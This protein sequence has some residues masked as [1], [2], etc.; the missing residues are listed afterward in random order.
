MC[1]HKSSI[2]LVVCNTNICMYVYQERSTTKDVK[3]PGFMLFYWF[4]WSISNF[5][6]AGTIYVLLYV[7]MFCKNELQA[8][9][10]VLFT[11]YLSN[12]TIVVSVKVL[13]TNLLCAP[14]HGV[15]TINVVW[16]SPSPL[17]L[18]PTMLLY[19]R[20]SILVSRTK[21]NCPK[22]YIDISRNMS[23]IFRNTYTNDSTWLTLG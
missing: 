9:L 12:N 5:R 2:R 8:K 1:L 3:A 16:Y 6:S 22:Q 11:L 4:I 18:T 23:I 15:E 20:S 17:L 21:E 7:Y 10:F 13:E 14:V 19:T